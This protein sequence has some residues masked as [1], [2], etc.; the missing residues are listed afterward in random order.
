MR[1]WLKDSLIQASDD[2]AADGKS[3]DDRTDTNQEEST[4]RDTTDNRPSKAL[5]LSGPGLGVNE[6]SHTPKSQ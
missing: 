1:L 5:G 4:R 6:H 2:R 3:L